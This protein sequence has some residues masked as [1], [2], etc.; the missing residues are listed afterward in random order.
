VW[1]TG[2]I[3]LEDFIKDHSVCWFPNDTIISRDDANF[4][5]TYVAIVSNVLCI[6]LCHMLCRLLAMHQYCCGLFPYGGH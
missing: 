3:Q 4:A 2:S 5:Q 6:L 1:T